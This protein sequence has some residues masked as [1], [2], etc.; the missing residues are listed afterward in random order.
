M[1]ANKLIRNP[2]WATL[3]A[4]LVVAMVSYLVFV[5]NSEAAPAAHGK[6]YPYIINGEPVPNG[7]YPFMVALLDQ[8][9]PGT[10]IDKLLCGGSLIDNTHV[11]T[12]GHCVSAAQR[13]GPPV[14]VP[15]R[16]DLQVLVGRT[17]LT[18]DQGHVRNVK[19]VDV[20][21]KYPGGPLTEPFDVAVLTL[22]RAVRGIKPIELATSNQNNLERPG[23]HATVAGWGST[24][25]RRPCA[26][27]GDEVIANHLQEVQVPIV[28]DSRADKVLQQVPPQ[29]PPGT[30]SPDVFFS[31]LMIAAGG[32]E[33][34][35][36]CQGDSGGPLFVR[37]SGHDDNGRN[38]DDDNGGKYTQIGITS[39]TS[40][41]GY[42][43]PDVY[44]EVNAQ[45]IASFIE[46]TADNG[47]GDNGNGDN[48]DDK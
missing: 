14:L 46:R 21:P 48:G 16:Q 13:T 23:R 40:G 3:L 27:G 35:G 11:L 30:P 32:A 19:A 36:S 39:F 41:C 20:H 4:A 1:T 2:L 33:D 17:V 8:S 44:T 38:G 28:S 47:D 31:Q 34:K 12:A 24:K 7:K 10:N 5:P 6:Y 43:I 26:R 18:S 9:R 29:C 22:S 37:T 25:P 42:G 15:K 45:P